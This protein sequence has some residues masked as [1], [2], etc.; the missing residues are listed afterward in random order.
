M[1]RWTD[2]DLRALVE[3][4]ARGDSDAWI[5]ESTGRTAGAVRQKR[6]ELGLRVR[7]VSQAAIR[8]YADETLAG[9]LRRRGFRVQAPAAPTVRRAPAKRAPA[10]TSQWSVRGSTR[11]DG[12][13]R[14]GVT[15]TVSGST[16]TAA[17]RAWARAV[18]QT[19]GDPL[20]PSASVRLIEEAP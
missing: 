6:G 7:P 16:P 15:H 12:G 3:G 1:S 17:R 13:T 14:R 2:K 4:F 10:D 11:V 18:R 9:E 5:G 20:M 19:G 8:D